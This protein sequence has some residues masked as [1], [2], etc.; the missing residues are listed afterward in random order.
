MQKVRNRS[1]RLESLEER[2]L[3]AVI[4]GM[5]STADEFIAPLPDILRATGDDAESPSLLITTLSDVVDSTDGLTS[6]REAIAYAER[7]SSSVRVSFANGLEG[8]ITLTGGAIA[9]NS[10]GGITIDGRNLITIDAG[11]S[12]RALGDPALLVRYQRKEEDGRDLCRP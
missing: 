11:G 8:T 4:G 2:A 10:A 5:E 3:L 12:G 9:V 6:I 7:F 1:L